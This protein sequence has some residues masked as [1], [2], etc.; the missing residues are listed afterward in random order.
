[1][2]GKFTVQLANVAAI[3]SRGLETMAE[4]RLSPAVTLSGHDT[5]T[6]AVVT[7]GDLEGNDVEGAPRHTFGIAGW[8]ASRLATFSMKARFV[9]DTF[10]DITNEATQDAHLIVDFLAAKPIGRSFEIFVTGENLF[11]DEYIADGFGESL[12][13]PRQ[14]S[15][16]VRLEF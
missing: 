15:A 6:D 5:F 1:V 16:G 2:N 8:Y 11:D 12:G 4:A 7:E 14:I 10:Q 3:R 13:P 9:D